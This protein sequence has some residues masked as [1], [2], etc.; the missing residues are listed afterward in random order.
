MEI[1][2]LDLKIQYQKIKKEI[3]IAIDE[4]LESQR[5]ILGDKVKRLEDKI[6]KY[7][8]CRFGIGVSSGTDAL[9]ISLMALDIKYGDIVI[10]TPYTFFSTVGVI[11]RLGAK[12]LFVDIDAKTY[13]MDPEKLGYLLER[14]AKDNIKAIIPIHLFGQCADMEPILELSNRFNIPVIEDA[15]QAIGAE[16]IKNGRRSRAG[17]MGILGC[18]S[19]FPSKNLGGY[20]DG[21]MVVTNNEEL[22]KKV[23]MLR[24]HGS[25]KKYYHIYVGIN[26]RL[27]ALQAAVLLVKIKYLDEW[28]KKRKENAEFYKELFEKIGYQKFDIKLPVTEYNNRHIYNQFV[29]RVKKRD[30]LKNFLKEKGI[31]TE[32]YYPLPLHMQ[33]C[34]KDLG[35]KEGDF[36]ESEKAA[37]ET[38][39]LPIFP[40]LTQNQQEY[41]VDMIKRFYDK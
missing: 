28:S 21:G 20:G 2:L 24:S 41:I 15:A 40:E 8:D 16:Y 39:A 37:K 32:I 13:N 14:K 35:Y 31:S 19:F 18:F 9:L 5:F 1:P 17:S 36:P 10:T 30:E 3:K 33:P 29:I 12:P 34:Y 26:G 4:V 27:D 6:A 25:E 38:L 23:R 7:S 11:T 22:A